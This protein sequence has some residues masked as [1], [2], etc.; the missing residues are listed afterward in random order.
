LANVVTARAF[1]PMGMVVS[2][3]FG[4]TIFQAAI[5]VGIGIRSECSGKGLCGKCRVMVKNT[6]ALSGL[7]EVEKQHLTRMEIES[8]YRLA[9]Q[10]KILKDVT[11]TIPLENRRGFRKIQIK[12]IEKSIK[13]NPS[14]IKINVIIIKIN[15]IIPKPTLKDIR[16]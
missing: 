13:L 11:I 1:E 16:P 8:D 9:C 7:T 14:V 6:E 3:S 10:A 2:I 4:I 12:G 5:K 15:V